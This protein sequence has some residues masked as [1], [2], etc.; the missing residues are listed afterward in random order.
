MRQA[1]EAIEADCYLD[2]YEMRKSGWQGKSIS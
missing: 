1:R 2:F